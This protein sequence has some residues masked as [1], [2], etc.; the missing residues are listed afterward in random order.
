MLFLSTIIVIIPVI[1]IIFIII[2]EGWS[3]IS[4]E[5]L[6]SMP[7]MGMR[8]GGIFPAIIGTLYLVIGTLIFA[9][10]LGILSAIF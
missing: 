3:A 1:F 9:I 2:K 8:E 6:T 4:W 10:P 7:R 5:F